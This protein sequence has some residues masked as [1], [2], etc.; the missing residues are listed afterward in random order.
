M[1]LLK[2]NISSFDDLVVFYVL[3]YPGHHLL[4]FENFGLQLISNIISVHR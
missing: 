3:Y 2:Y 1:L 4:S